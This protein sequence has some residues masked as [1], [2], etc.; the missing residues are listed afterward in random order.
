MQILHSGQNQHKFDK[1]C[2]VSM[3]KIGIKVWKSPLKHIL[4][5]SSPQCLEGRT[6]KGKRTLQV[7]HQKNWCISTFSDWSS[8]L[9][10][11]SQLTWIYLP[12]LLRSIFSANIGM[13][14]YLFCRSD[15]NCQSI[16]MYESFIIVHIQ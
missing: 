14:S 11:L 16:F 13:L 15:T 6:Q 2:K 7:L 5:Y 4:T 12:S 9:Q 10:K 3:S 8:V 1:F